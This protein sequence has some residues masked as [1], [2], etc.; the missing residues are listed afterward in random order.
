MKKTLLTIVA[1]FSVCT[2]SIAHASDD[3]V[4]ITLVAQDGKFTPTEIK[5]P[6]GKRVELT[7]ENKG[8]SAEEFES[9]E[10]K[11]EKVVPAG[12]TVK[13]VLGTLKKGTYKFFGDYHADTAKGVI[14]AE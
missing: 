4:Q 3:T 13:I 6:A 5:V 10:L 11:R 2:V 1:L 8:T 7:V 9:K 14:I 12:K